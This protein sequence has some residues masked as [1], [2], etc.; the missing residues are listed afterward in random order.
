MIN[1]FK[2][3][4]NLW[5]E[6]WF[7][8]TDL[9]TLGLFRL[10]LG[11]ILFLNYGLRHLNLSLFYYADGIV[12][13]DV[14]ASIFEGRF[15]SLLYW[16]P[17]E[18]WAV[19]LLHFGFLGS[20]LLLTLGVLPRSMALVALFIHVL[21]EQRNYMVVYGADKVAACWLL[22]LILCDS[23]QHFSLKQ[24]FREGKKFLST[25]LL[26]P[27]GVRLIQIQLCLIYAYSGL[28]KIKGPSWWSGGAVWTILTNGGLFPFDFSLVAQVPVLIAVATYGTLI[29]ETY[30]PFAILSPSLRKPWL[31]F[32]VFFHLMIA[33]TMNL[34]F[35]SALMIVSYLFFYPLSFRDRA[36]A[37]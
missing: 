4:W 10:I 25:D 33:L 24:R 14:G 32:G 23:A 1:I 34:F 27:V 18:P 19:Q 28:E 12:P 9:R 17:V 20:L 26:S 35:F 22:Y 2:K 30:F 5:D 11:A 36:Q 3:I 6:F 8:P 13:P 29:F 21:F 16:F 7:S 31:I 15:H 37:T